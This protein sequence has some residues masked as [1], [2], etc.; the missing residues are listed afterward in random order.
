MALFSMR[1]AMAW[2]TSSVTASKGERAEAVRFVE[3]RLDIRPCVVRH[4]AAAGEVPADVQAPRL[5]GAGEGADDFPRQHD[6]GA[7]G[8]V[9]DKRSRFPR[10]QG[11]RAGA[12]ADGIDHILQLVPSR[13]WTG[14][15][16]RCLRPT[17]DR[18]P[19]RPPRCC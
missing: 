17:A 6:L 18:R 13:P 7:P 5:A 16:R 3:A 15:S 12:A 11:V 8:A 9:I 14:R 2:R 1:S 10:A 19:C 4:A